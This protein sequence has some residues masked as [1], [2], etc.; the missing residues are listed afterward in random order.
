MGFEE[1]VWIGEPPTDEFLASASGIRESALIDPREVSARLAG[2]PASF[3]RPP[4][5]PSLEWV[6]SVGLQPRSLGTLSCTSSWAFP[7]RS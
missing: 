5:P 6:A 7:Q 1:A 4:C 3:V 2:C